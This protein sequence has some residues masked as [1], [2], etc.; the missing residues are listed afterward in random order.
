MEHYATGTDMA[1]AFAKLANEIRF[2][3]LRRGSFVYY[4][5]FKAGHQ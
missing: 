1:I 2:I 3:E 4:S 5:V